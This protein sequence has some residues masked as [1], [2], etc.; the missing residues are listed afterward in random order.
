V[1][2]SATGAAV[3]DIFS[4]IQRRFPACRIY[5]RPTLVQGEGSAED[6]AMAISELNRT[7]AE[8]LIIGRGGGSMEDLWA[9]NTEIVADAIYHSKKPVISAVGHE[10]DFTIADFVADVRAA[11]P[12]AAAELATPRTYLV[13]EDY[14]NSL[15]DEMRRSM[16]LKIREQKDLVY[17]RS[18]AASMRRLREKINIYKQQIDEYESRS[19][20]SIRKEIKINMN[21]VSALESHCK[22]L[23][24]L[25]PLDKGFAI[26]KHDGKILANE[27]SLVDYKNVEIVRA[28]ESAL[29]TIDKVEKRD[30]NI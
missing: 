1:A 19:I 9:F 29:A 20:Q 2:T 10:T 8:V 16:M 30:N 26:I 22:S 27:E 14:I 12:T 4:T 11:T 15:Q 17:N 23:Y 21:R 5:F 25:S 3:K 6:V 24:P 7:D 28:H 18:G 13:I